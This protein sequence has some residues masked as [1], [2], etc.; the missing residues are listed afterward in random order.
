VIDWWAVAANAAW[1]SGLA[2]L[3]AVWNYRRFRRPD[4]PDRLAPFTLLGW[5]LLGLGL[6]GIS[7]SWLTGLLTIVLL[8]ILAL[9]T[10]RVLWQQRTNRN[11]Q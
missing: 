7:T 4:D 8:T 11:N 9:P 2:L 1:M 3:F 5:L 6:W 10:V